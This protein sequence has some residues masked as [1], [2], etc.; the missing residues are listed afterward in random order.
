MNYI[1]FEIGGKSRGFHL[2]LGFL[3]DILKYLDVDMV[4]FGNLL[5]KNPYLSV[6]TILF[7]SHKQFE[8]RKGKVLDV[9]IYDVEDWIEN[10]KG[11][12]YSKNIESLLE[13]L[14]DTV[15]KHLPKTEDESGGNEQ[16][17]N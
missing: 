8:L 11:G 16:K 9:N 17:K 14:L 6:P 13:L 5:T 2:G 3:G 15:M 4:G 10:E 1:E 12:V 7:L